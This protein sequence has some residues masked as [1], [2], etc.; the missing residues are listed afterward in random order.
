[1]D[2]NWV[3]NTIDGNTEPIVVQLDGDG[4]TEAVSYEEAFGGFDGE[5]F[6]EARGRRRRRRFRFRRLLKKFMKVFPPAIAL[7]MAKKAMR[8]RKR[9]SSKPAIATAALASMPMSSTA[10]APAMATSMTEPAGTEAGAEATVEAPATENTSPEAAIT[11]QASEDPVQP[12]EQGPATDAEQ[13]EEAPQKPSYSDDEAQEG[14]TSEAEQSIDQETGESDEAAG[15]TGS[16]GADGVNQKSEVDSFWDNF[17]ASAEGEKRIVPKVM[18]LAQRIEKNKAFIAEKIDLANRMRARYEKNPSNVTEADTERLKTVEH[19]IDAHKQRL[20]KLEKHLAELGG[21]QSSA[22]GDI[23]AI[24]RRNAMIRRAKWLARQERKQWIRGQR[25]TR[26]TKRRARVAE[27]AQQFANQGMPPQLARA[28]A[29]QQA[30]QEIPF[31]TRV[32]AGIG[33]QIG[34]QR[35][36]IPDQMSSAEGTGLIGVDNAYDYDAPPVR[37]VELNFSNADGIASKFDVK[38]VIIG[39]GIA[40]LVIYAYKKKWLQHLFK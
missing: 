34:P 25:L 1:M 22:N 33:A 21:T 9:K 24:A 10:Q 31:L 6:Y 32:Q 36:E 12:E 14:D 27:L 38:H 20:V 3:N 2:I 30:I 8:K 29:R 11:D 28:K 15:F 4:E 16:S 17:F 23:R 40:A 7:K 37:T 39:G 13:S 19:Q 5:D 26:R 18:E 35:I